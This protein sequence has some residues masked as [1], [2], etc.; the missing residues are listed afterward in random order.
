MVKSDASNVDQYLNELPDDRKKILK[1]VRET[2]LKNL[3]PGF[4]ET[5]NWGMISYEIPLETFS[6]T[7]NKQ[8][9]LFAALASQKQYFF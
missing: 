7:Y 3:N 4:R 6:D 1:K 9:L 2:I 8:P 5:M